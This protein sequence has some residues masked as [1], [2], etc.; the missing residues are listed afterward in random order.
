MR[1]RKVSYLLVGWLAQL[2]L[3][4]DPEAF[5]KLSQSEAWDK[6]TMRLF[7]LAMTGL[8]WPIM[9]WQEKDGQSKKEPTG[10]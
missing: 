1:C 6:F 8:I 2:A 9:R 10:A 4:I 3:I 7:S 5:Q